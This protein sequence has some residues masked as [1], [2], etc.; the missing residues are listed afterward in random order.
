MEIFLTFLDEKLSILLFYTLFVNDFIFEMLVL[1][2]VD[3]LGPLFHKLSRT[4]L[5]QL[6]FSP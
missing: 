4:G 3:F 6:L 5:Q 1:D 2:V